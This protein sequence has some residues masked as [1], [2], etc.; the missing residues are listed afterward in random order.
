MPDTWLPTCTAM[1][2]LIVPVAV[3]ACVIAPRSIGVTLYLTGG[4]CSLFQ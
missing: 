4:F 3:T 1:T 2:G